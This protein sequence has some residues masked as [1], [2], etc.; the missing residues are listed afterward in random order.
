VQKSGEQLYA[1]FSRT[2]RS[3]ISA[4]E[5]HSTFVG[6]MSSAKKNCGFALD[7]PPLISS[8]CTRGGDGLDT[9]CGSPYKILHCRLSHR[10]SRRNKKGAGRGI[11]GNTTSWLISRSLV[12]P[13]QSWKEVHKIDMLE[14]CLLMACALG[15][16]TGLTTPTYDLFLSSTDSFSCVQLY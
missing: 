14:E 6:Q 3:S 13:E 16:V 9:P 4:L 2:R 11:H 8:C 12:T 15:T 1:T 10:T 7:C 5:E